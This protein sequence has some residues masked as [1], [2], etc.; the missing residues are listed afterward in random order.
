MMVLW[1]NYG[2]PVKIEVQI[3]SALSKFQILEKR[4]PI[5]AI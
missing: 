5:V 4:L 1:D 3:Y 2:K